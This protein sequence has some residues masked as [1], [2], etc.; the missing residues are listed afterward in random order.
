MRPDLMVVIQDGHLRTSRLN[1][2]AE[3]T[4]LIR[5][6]EILLDELK[7]KRWAAQQPKQSLKRKG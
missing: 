7:D 5:V 3:L 1:P 2:S 6:V 4:P